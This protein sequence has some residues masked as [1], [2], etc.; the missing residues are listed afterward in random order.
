MNYAIYGINRVAKDFMYMFPELNITAFVDDNYHGSEYDGKKVF[1]SGSLTYVREIADSV[2]ICGFDNKDKENKLVSLEC[3]H[4]TDYLFADDFFE[5]VND[6]GKKINPANKKVVIWGTGDNAKKFSVYFPHFNPI[7]YIDS[8]KNTDVFFEKPVKKP[9]N[10]SNWNEYFVIIAVQKDQEIVDRLKKI[11]MQQ[12]TDFVNANVV[13]NTPSEM[14]RATIYDKHMYN[15]HCLTPLNHL[16]LLTD[17]NLYCCCSTF[18]RSIGSVKNGQISDV[19]KS[20]IHRIICLSVLNRTYTFCKKNMCPLFFGKN[21]MTQFDEHSLM[22][23]KYEEMRPTPAVTA[24]GFDYTCNL[25]CETCRNETRVAVKDEQERMFRLADLTINELLAK[26]EF[27][28][29]AGDGEVFF[30]PAY[31]KIYQSPQ[32]NNVPYIRILSN[33][34]LFNEDNWDVFKKNKSG[35]ILLTASVD[36]ATKATYESIRRN[37]NFDILKRNMK[38]AG[39][40]R[41]HGDLAYFRMN[42]VVQRHNYQEIPAFIKWGM[43]IGADEVFFTKILNWGTFSADEFRQIS[44]FEDDGITPKQELKI[45]LD[46]PLLKEKIVDLGTIRYGHDTATD[47]DIYNYYMWELERKVPGLFKE[48]LHK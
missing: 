16:E 42:F 48:T 21:N 32:M 22:Q 29:L 33:G 9:D 7:F 14:L 18:M 28:V 12:D 39:D 44:M 40:L 19:W 36:A 10:I 38:F 17:G 8:Y 35:K 2:I 11:G 3:K 27:F 45:V 23:C 30:S 15:L 31:K 37:G 25:K 13:M 1:P 43:E 41:K 5:S 26:T 24:I 20:K 4:F 47:I 46:N 6:Y 34:T